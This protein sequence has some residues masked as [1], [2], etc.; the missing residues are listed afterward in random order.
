M[1]LLK[2]KINQWLQAAIITGAQ[3]EKILTFE[4][5]RHRFL[6]GSQVVMLGLIVLSL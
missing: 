2:A 4:A 3:A 6:A 1:V 5:A